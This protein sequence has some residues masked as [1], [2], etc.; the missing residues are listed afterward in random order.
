M[1]QSTFQEAYEQEWIKQNIANP[2]HE[3]VILR[4][5]IPWQKIIEQLLRFYDAQ[6]GCM[7]K[8]LRV[9]V[10]LLVVSKLRHLSDEQVVAQVKENRYLQY[11]C[12][13][14]DKGLQTFLDKSSLCKFR[15]RIGEEGVAIIEAEVFEHLR[16]CGIIKADTC[17]IDATVLNN[18]IVYPND[19]QLIF[20]AFGKMACFA[21]THH[22]PL[23]WDHQ[24]VKKLWRAFGL[25][26]GQ[27]RVAYL[28]QF[29]LLFVPALEIFW[30]QVEAL[31][32]SKKKKQKAQSLA[33]LLTL[34]QM[35][36]QEKL[37]GETHIKNR[38]V[39]LDEVDAR[40]IKRGKRYPTCEFGT[41][42]QMSLNRQGFMIT[43]EN[44]IG[45]Q[46]DT[47]LYPN[48]FALFQKRM[49]ANPDTTVTD[50]GFRS[51]KNLRLTSKTV[52][53][54]FM[55]RSEDVTEEK[56]DF[57]K[58]VRS[59]TEG[60]IA[61]AKNWRGFGCSLYRGFGGDRIW[62]LLC[63]TAYNLKKF[64]Q[65]YWDEDLEETSLV[66]LGLLG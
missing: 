33:D 57:C 9:M 42:L 47:T 26:K 37:D 6:K 61:V 34:L 13:V 7:G 65:L 21:K 60:F 46:N 51:A 15:K 22:L 10:A 32:A 27:N 11:F 45:A 54:V 2:N 44:L 56:Q 28:T 8:S 30:V 48:T 52:E 5:V 12:N 62:T 4:Q 25:N 20:K 43:T 41:T 64:L 24:E 63:Q 49:K 53:T 31:E 18:N 1:I 58:S 19:V 29:H 55:G 40:P 14:P 17:L 36:T 3:L 23:W 50:L 38:I 66:K 59:A 16:R 35:Q 39:S